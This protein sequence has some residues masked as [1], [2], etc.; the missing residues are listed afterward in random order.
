MSAATDLAPPVWGEPAYLDPTTGRLVTPAAPPAIVAP[1]EAAPKVAARCQSDP[2]APV[3]AVM[4]IAVLL[5]L[6]V[7]LVA[8]RLVGA[9]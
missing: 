1:A 9:L 5:F 4:L 8:L 7:V 2:T 3:E 6:S